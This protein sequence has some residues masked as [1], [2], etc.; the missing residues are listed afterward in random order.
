[1]VTCSIFFSQ[2][3]KFPQ[4]FLSKKLYHE[5]E[6]GDILRKVVFRPGC[7]YENWNNVADKITKKVE[8]FRS[9]MKELY[10]VTL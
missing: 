2:T 8:S 1:M 7:S 3:V 5:F 9:F 4:N 10:E 6:A